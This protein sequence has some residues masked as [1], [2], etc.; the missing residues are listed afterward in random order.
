M[1]RMTEMP[2]PPSFAPG[3]PGRFWGLV[4]CAGTGSRA[5]PAG[6]AADLPKQYQMVAG[7]S[8]TSAP[9]AASFWPMRH[10]VARRSLIRSWCGENWS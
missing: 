9:W 7:T 5:V 3:T 1:A 4:P 2:A 8:T 6:A 10:S